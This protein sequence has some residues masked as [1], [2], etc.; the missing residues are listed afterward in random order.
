MATKSPKNP[1]PDFVTGTKSKLWYCGFCGD[2]CI[3]RSI[4]KHLVKPQQL[5]KRGSCGEV[6]VEALREV[7]CFCA[8]E[9]AELAE[10]KI[11]EISGGVL[12]IG[13]PGENQGKTIGKPWENYR[14]MVVSLDFM[15]CTLWL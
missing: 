4:A 13:K 14:N 9:D 15:R 5:G 8:A 7:M 11:Q 3:P 10:Q 2:S 12:T 6:T 1:Y